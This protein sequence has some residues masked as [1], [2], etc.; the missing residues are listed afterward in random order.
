MTI[1]TSL[2]P[3]IREAQQQT[4]Q[5]TNYPAEQLRGLDKQ[6]ETTTDGVLYFK[7]RIWVP[8]FGNVRTII[9]DEAHKSRYSVH[10]GA[11]KMYKDF[12]D[13]Y[14]WPAMKKHIAKYVD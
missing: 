1:Q 3:H 6:L 4:L 13:F 14:S 5:A 9:L 11:D 12:K 10:S 8:L 7:S 2:I